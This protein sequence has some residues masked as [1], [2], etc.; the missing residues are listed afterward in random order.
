M[1]PVCK[2]VGWSAVHFGGV[3]AFYRSVEL[4]VGRSL[5]RHVS[6]FFLEN[7]PICTY[8]CLVR[9]SVGRSARLF[10]GSSVGRSI[11]QSVGLL[12][13]LPVILVG[14]Q[15]GLLAHFPLVFRSFFFS[16]VS[17]SAC[18]FLFVL[19]FSP[20][21]SVYVGLPLLSVQVCKR[22]HLDSFLC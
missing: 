18:L 20:S 5:G 11:R 16:L 15:V 22:T 9:R 17:M 2:E 4:S 19:L 7:A 6:F 12:V 13:D 10:V 3:S 21:A 14:F 1:L 8:V